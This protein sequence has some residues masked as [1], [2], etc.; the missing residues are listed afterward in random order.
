[1]TLFSC[2]DKIYYL[3]ALIWQLFWWKLNL[4]EQRARWLRCESGYAHAAA[5]LCSAAAAAAVYLPSL[6]CSLFVSLRKIACMQPIR[7]YSTN[8][9]TSVTRKEKAK[10]K[11]SQQKLFCLRYLVSDRRT[12][13]VHEDTLVTCV[14]ATSGVHVGIAWDFV[15]DR[16][17]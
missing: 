8:K 10:K 1:M 11:S 6:H 12:R 9:R 2:H 5:V 16:E 14:R 4:V 13:I 7:S 17:M 15:G 3:S